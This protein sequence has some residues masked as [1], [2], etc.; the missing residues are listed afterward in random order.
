MVLFF[1]DYFVAICS[2]TEYRITCCLGSYGQSSFALS[3]FL[4]KPQL[5]HKLFTDLSFHFKPNSNE[6]VSLTV[7][8]ESINPMN[9]QVKD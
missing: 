1:N 3:N 6:I 7:L 2:S 8:L 5:F 4:L 9:Q